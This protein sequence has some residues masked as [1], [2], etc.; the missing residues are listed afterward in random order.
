MELKTEHL[1]EG[2]VKFIRIHCKEGWID[3]WIGD[4]I[5]DPNNPTKNKINLNSSIT[6]YRCNNKKWIIDKH[7]G[8]SKILTLLTMREEFTAK[9]IW[10]ELLRLKNKKS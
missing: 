3:R 6:Y 10:D 4:C 9:E 5:N 7:L 8:G 1:E 2:W